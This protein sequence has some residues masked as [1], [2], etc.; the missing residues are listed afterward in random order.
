[1]KQN[2]FLYIIIAVLFGVIVFSAYQKGKDAEKRIWQQKYDLDIAK[3]NFKADSLDKVVQKLLKNLDS[4]KNLPAKII[5]VERERQDQIDSTIKKD[6]SKAIVEYRKGLISLGTLPD[7]GVVLTNREIGFGAKYFSQLQS[8]IDLLDVA[9]Q[10]Q[11]KQDDIIGTLRATNKELIKENHLLKTQ[12]NEKDS[13]SF[14]DNRFPLIL[15]GGVGYDLDRKVISG[16]IG[17][18]WGVRIN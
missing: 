14:W 2:L 12:N 6:S 10:L 5:E 11:L 18:Y 9:Y 4:L 1:M 8:K 15:G 17:I 7:S 16:S 3:A 13:E